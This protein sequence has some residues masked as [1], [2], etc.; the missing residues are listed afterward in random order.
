MDQTLTREKKIIINIMCTLQKA[1]KSY[2]E[3]KRALNREPLR[4]VSTYINRS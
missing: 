2:H 4:M 1:A 3:M